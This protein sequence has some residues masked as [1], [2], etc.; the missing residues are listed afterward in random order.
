MERRSFLKKAVAGAAATTLAAPA[1]AQS[2]PTISWRMAASWPKSLDTLFGGMDHCE[3]E[4]CTSVYSPAS[5]FVELLQ[6]LRNNDLD[7]TKPNLIHNGIANTPLE[8]AMAQITE[9]WLAP[10]RTARCWELRPDVAPP[11]GMPI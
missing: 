11:P 10:T 8:K 9:D 3:C 6:Y 7:P 1:I 5:Y 4:D 2:H